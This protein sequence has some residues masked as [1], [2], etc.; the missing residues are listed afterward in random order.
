AR[1]ETED[2]V[3]QRLSLHVPHSTT[4]WQ[5]EDHEAS[6][7]RRKDAGAESEHLVDW[8]VTSELITEIDRGKAGADEAFGQASDTV[9]RWT[10]SSDDVAGCEVFDE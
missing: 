6:N 4:P 9:A 3:R 7:W 1:I 10:E 2:E 5:P 8:D